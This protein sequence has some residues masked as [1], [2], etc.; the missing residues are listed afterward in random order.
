MSEIRTHVVF[1]A[2]EYVGMV[3]D[4]PEPAEDAAP[5][6][7][8]APL[9]PTPEGLALTHVIAERLAADGWDV[10]HHWTTD[11]SHAFEA[12]RSK[13]RYDLM[14]QYTEAVDE[15]LVTV[16]PRKGLMGRVLGGVDPNEHRVLALHLHS[17]LS[18]DPLVG[19]DLRWF[20]GDGWKA[21]R[22]GDGSGSETPS[23]S[24]D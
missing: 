3:F 18:N 2:P 15:W 1:T 19:S 22:P 11:Y 4:A 9:G 6:Y 20:T 21:R 12:R 17:A 16:L 10:P 13:R 24:A 8:D 5:G 14:V 23:I 7:D